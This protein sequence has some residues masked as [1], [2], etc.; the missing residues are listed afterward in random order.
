MDVLEA[1]VI[2]VYTFTAENCKKNKNQLNIQ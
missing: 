1:L 2:A